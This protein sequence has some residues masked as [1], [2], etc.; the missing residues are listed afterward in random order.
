M[1]IMDCYNDNVDVDYLITIRKIYI[2]IN[3]VLLLLNY[4]SSYILTPT[5]K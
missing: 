1:P 2:P 5:N 3:S 4:I